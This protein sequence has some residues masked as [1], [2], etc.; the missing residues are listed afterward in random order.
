MRL[1]IHCAWRCPSRR[2]GNEAIAGNVLDRRGA[3]R[4]GRRRP[5]PTR[6]HPQRKSW[7]IRWTTR[8][9]LTMCVAWRQGATARWTF[10]TTGSWSSA[11]GAAERGSTCC[12]VLVRG[13]AATWC[14]PSR[15]AARASAAATCSAACHASGRR[16]LRAF[17]HLGRFVLSRRTTWMPSGVPCAP[18]ARTGQSRKRFVRQPRPK[19]NGHSKRRTLRRAYR[20]GRAS[21]SR[22]RESGRSVA[23]RRRR[24][25]PLPRRESLRRGPRSPARTTCRR[26]Q[27]P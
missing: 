13:C 14:S 12:R 11:G 21:G 1:G 2:Y 15:P 6:F 26:G 24:R 8:P 27:C 22:S 25:P 10:S 7:P 5:E 18:A 19:T 17:V 3:G 9:T 23:R 4:G 16:P 20:R